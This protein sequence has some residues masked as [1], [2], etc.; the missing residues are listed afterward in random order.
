MQTVQQKVRL[1]ILGPGRIT[2]RVMADWDNIENVE[3]TAIASRDL[4]RAQ[5]AAKEYGAPIAYGSY[6]EMAQSPEVELVYIATPHPFHLAQAKL[7]M[8]HGKHV[9]CEKPMTVNDT[10]AAEMLACAKANG[11]FYMEAMWTRFLPATKEM[12]R[13]LR[14]GAIGQVRHVAM[15]FCYNN[16]QPDPEDR[17]FNPAL[18]GGALLDLGV[19]PIMAATHI[20]GW[21]PDQVQSMCVKASTGVDMRTCLQMHFPS[22]ATAQMV[23]GMDAAGN[24]GM[25]VYGTKGYIFMPDFWRP[26]EFTIIGADGQPRHVEFKPEHEGHHYEFDHAAECIRAGLT[27]SPLVT[28]AESLAVSR[29]CTNIRREQGI[30][31]PG[32]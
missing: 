27:E 9:L 17:I 30:L 8:E 22:G 6:E 31:Y 19:Y 24:N 18:A 5:A 3:L 32:E 20:F 28:W 11:V 12:M 16:P 4:A 2:A 10:E 13:L 26:H 21:E 23:C 14:E 29:L 15:E 7:M 25:A 1:G